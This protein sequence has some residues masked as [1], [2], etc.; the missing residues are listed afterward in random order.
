MTENLKVFYVYAF[1][2]A[3]DSV[4]GP[5]Y[6]PYYIGKGSGSR[7]FRRQGRTIPSPKDKSF[8][9]F[10]QEGLTEFEAF[11]MEKYCIALYGRIDLGSGILRNLT[12]GGEGVSGLTVSQETRLKISKRLRG[13][14]NPLWGRRGELSALWGKTRSEETR[15]KISKA[16]QKEKHHQWGKPLSEE[17]KRKIGEA[18]RGKTRSPETRRKMSESQTGRVHSSES[19]QK[20]SL[21]KITRLYELVDPDG[22]IYI[23]DNLSDFSK[24]YNLERTGLSRTVS[25]QTKH[26]KH[27]TGR[28]LA[29]LK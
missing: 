29:I 4:N 20:I 28:I 6:S 19:K 26:H 23:T 8:I 17:T 1:L 25:G 16:Q 12:D 9:V 14:N 7:A 5:R 3:N 24:Q 21:A 2:R 18:G 22:E 13:P 15:Q 11:A 10:I 27:W